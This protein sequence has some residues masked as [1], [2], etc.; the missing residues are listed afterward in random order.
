MWVAQNTFDTLN[1]SLQ[2]KLKVLQ[3]FREKVEDRI[4]EKEDEIIRL[5]EDID[6]LLEN[7]NDDV[8]TKGELDHI[9]RKIKNLEKNSSKHSTKI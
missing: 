9:K 8:I 7:T 4:S 2:H 1:T 3:E 5:D 6:D